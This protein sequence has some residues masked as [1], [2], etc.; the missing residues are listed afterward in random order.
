MKLLL[1]WIIGVLVVSIL[2]IDRHILRQT[3]NYFELETEILVGTCV[4]VIGSQ[5]SKMEC[6]NR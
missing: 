5:S 4:F 2:K 3:G 6:N 1:N